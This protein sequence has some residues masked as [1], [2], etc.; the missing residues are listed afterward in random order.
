MKLFGKHNN[1]KRD[2]YTVDDKSI[3]Y[4]SKSMMGR[5]H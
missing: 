5:I 2:R 3:I 4:L 1:H